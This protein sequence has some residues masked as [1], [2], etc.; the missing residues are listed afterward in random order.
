MRAADDSRSRHECRQCCAFCDHV[1]QPAGC[2]EGNCPYLYLYD[3]ELSGRRYM[4][5]LHKVFKA[6]IDVEVYQ[7]AQRTRRGFGGVKVANAPRPQCRV[8]VEQAYNGFGK[9]FECVNRQ[10][11]DLEQLQSSQASFDL[12]DRL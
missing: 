10:F 9:A 2:V 7:Q 12:R 1:V 4:G 8:S 6:E 11:F 5:C 3:D